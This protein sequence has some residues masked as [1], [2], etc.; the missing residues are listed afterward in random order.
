MAKTIEVDEE[1]LLQDKKLRDTVAT[2]MRHPKA[3]LLVQEAHKMVDPN[4]VTPD[5]DQAKIAYE[6]VQELSKKFDEFVAETKKEKTEREAADKL[7]KLNTDYEKG[8]SGLKAQKWTDDGIK[9][10]E[11]FMEQ[12]GI[13]D[14]EIAAAAF[15]KLHPPQTPVV[16]GGSGAWNFMEMPTDGADADLKKLIESKGENNLLIDKMAHD[17]INEVRGQ[18]RR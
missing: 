11:E 7:A 5:L 15:E 10:L 17:A 16:P 8:R 4:A 6:P 1:Q 3:K 9:K 2:M 18:P 12:K 13:L 14:H